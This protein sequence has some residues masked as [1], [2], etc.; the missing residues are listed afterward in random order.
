MDKMFCQRIVDEINL[1]SPIFEAE[2]YDLRQSGAQYQLLPLHQE[3]DDSHFVIA[4]NQLPEKGFY[5]NIIS[6]NA[7]K[8]LDMKLIAGFLLE[9]HTKAE[10]STIKGIDIYEQIVEF[11]NNLFYQVMTN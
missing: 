7:C 11:V 1:Y 10:K 5:Q 9:I 8:S 4:M 6:R 3:V 2:I